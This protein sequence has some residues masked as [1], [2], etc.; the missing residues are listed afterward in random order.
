MAILSH[1]HSRNLPPL[2][3]VFLLFFFGKRRATPGNGIQIH[4]C[5]DALTIAAAP[6]DQYERLRGINRVPENAIQSAVLFDWL[7]GD[8]YARHLTRGTGLLAPPKKTKKTTA[9]IY[10]GVACRAALKNHA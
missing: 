1:H 3:A 4:L 10:D 7:R 6:V 2:A 8:L 5:R 9:S